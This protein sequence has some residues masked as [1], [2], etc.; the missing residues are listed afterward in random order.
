MTKNQIEYN[1]ML[2][3]RRANKAQEQLTSLRDT[4]A[5]ELGVQNLG[6]LSRHNRATEAQASQVL[7]ET[8]RHNLATE[9]AQVLQLQE[10]QR[11]NMAREEISRGNLAET[12]RSNVAREEET[13]RSNIARETETQRHNVESE[14]QGVIQLNEMQRSNLAN[15]AIRRQ[16]NAIQSAYNTA[17]IAEATRSHMAQESTLR[18][19]ANTASRRASQDYQTE[20]QKLA[21]QSQYNAGVIDLRGKELAQRQAELGEQTRS[22]MVNEEEQQRHNVRTESLQARKLYYDLI[23]SSVRAAAPAIIGLGG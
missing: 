19:Q 3:T 5:Y 8:S 4:R 13:K 22:H 16:A 18:Q 14:R 1:K 12:V 11:A 20:Q 6:E 17:S 21:I 2:E 10:T 15:E 7:G 9:Q 23:T